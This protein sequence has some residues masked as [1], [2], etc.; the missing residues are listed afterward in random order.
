MFNRGILWA[1][2]W[3]CAA[4]TCVSANAISDWNEKT[5]AFVTARQ[6]PPPQAERVMAM[7]HVAMFAAGNSIERPYRPGVTQLLSPATASK[8]AAAA[9]AAGTVLI[10]LY[11]DA[12]ELKGAMAAYLAAMPG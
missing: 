1:I 4:T 9:A 3:S 8:E 2:V 6:V 7:V 11:P 12:V 5:V 10:G